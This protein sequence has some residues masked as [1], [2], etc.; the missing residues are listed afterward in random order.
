MLKRSIAILSV[1]IGM[2][3]LLLIS[4]SKN[5]HETIIHLGNESYKKPLDSIYPKKYRDLWKTV[6]PSCSDKVYEGIFPPDITGFYKMKGVC[7]GSDVEIFNGLEYIDLYSLSP[8]YYH[9]QY[10]YFMVEEQMNG[11]A[12]IKFVT[13][14]ST[15][16]TKPYEW[17]EAEAYISGN[18][19]NGCFTIT[20]EHWL[21]QPDG[22]RFFKAYIVNGQKD[23]TN[24][25]IIKNME[26]WSVIKQR[27]PDE[28]QP[29]IAKIGGQMM[30][31]ESS[32]VRKELE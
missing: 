17:N 12:K 27:K 4:C 20:F 13:R 30:Y 9:K 7:S 23:I 16:P 22:K 29:G 8:S 24:D 32:V 5:N 15:P 2:V 19:A 6:A 26:F 14:Y 31:F 25:T 28:N 18:G 3:V 11:I 1:V 10:L 21:D